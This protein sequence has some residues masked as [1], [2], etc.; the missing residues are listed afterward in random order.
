VRARITIR[1]IDKDRRLWKAKWGKVS[2]EKEG[3]EGG[4]ESGRQRAKKEEKGNLRT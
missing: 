2:L 3:D 4:R 1:Y